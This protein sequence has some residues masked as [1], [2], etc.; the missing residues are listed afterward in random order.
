MSIFDFFWLFIAPF[1]SVLTIPDCPRTGP[2]VRDYAIWARGGGRVHDGLPL[3]D[4]RRPSLRDRTLVI[5]LQAGLRVAGSMHN[6]FCD[7]ETSQQAN[8]AGLICTATGTEKQFTV[9][10]T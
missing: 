6:Y 7:I 10:L 1:K 5:R 2:R 3:P 9:C 4:V 8:I